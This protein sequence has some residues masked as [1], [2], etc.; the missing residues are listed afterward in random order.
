MKRRI[1]KTVIIEALLAGR[2]AHYGRKLT[3]EERER[4]M[5]QAF[6]RGMRAAAEV[7]LE[8]AGKQRRA[9]QAMGRRQ[10]PRTARLASDRITA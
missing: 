4:F 8:W 3:D 1:P 2:A 5:S 10:P 6:L 7:I 9:A